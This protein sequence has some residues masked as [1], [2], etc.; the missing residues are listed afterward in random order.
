MIA[1]R[2]TLQGQGVNPFTVS[3]RNQ[4]NEI[5]PLGSSIAYA[6]AND[7]GLI[8]PNIIIGNNVAD[9]DGLLSNCRNFRANLQIPN[10]VTKCARL[11]EL[12]YNLNQNI[13]LPDAAENCMSIFRDCQALN[14]NIKI[15]A[16]AT[17][18]AMM[19]YNCRQLNQ[20]IAIPDNVKNCESMFGQCISLNQNIKI[21]ESAIR[22]EAMFK[23]ACNL[24][25]KN[26][27]IPENVIDVSNLLM[28]YSISEPTY[29]K[30]INIF[31]NA[32]EYKI[33]RIDGLVGRYPTQ[34]QP[35][36]VNTSVRKNIF[37]N[38]VLNNVFNRTNGST[39]LGYDSN[40]L[41]T[42]TPMTNGFYNAYYNF[43]CYYN[44]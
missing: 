14:Y 19:F 10:G 29:N 13:L 5:I 31:F 34:Y 26:L 20:N 24:D 44:Y 42:W 11:F 18:C 7:Q 3:I 15:P 37:F 8:N 39:I 41:I 1:Y 21:P 43:Y 38:A 12:C 28:G 23:G 25:F 9:I 2:S 36:N 30:S 22:C 27:Y 16:N 6:Y 33:I 4:N 17:D 40:D 35:G 32:R